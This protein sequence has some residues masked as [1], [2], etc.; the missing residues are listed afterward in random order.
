[1]TCSFK[2]LIVLLCLGLTCIG[3]NRDGVVIQRID[4]W[5]GPFNRYADSE[6]NQPTPVHTQ[7]V[8]RTI[9]WRAFPAITPRAMS[10]KAVIL[11][12]SFLNVA[13]FRL[14]SSGMTYAVNPAEK[15]FRNR[16]DIRA[17]NTKRAGLRTRL[18]EPRSLPF[19]TKIHKQ[20]YRR[21]RNAAKD[22]TEYGAG[23]DVSLRQRAALAR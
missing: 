15:A 22:D 21:Y 11:F 17:S 2:C 7:R 10:T 23:R 1:M 5:L 3:P 12:R 14:A 6:T 8:A 13:A 9:K 20:G 4:I 16:T 18:S 19:L